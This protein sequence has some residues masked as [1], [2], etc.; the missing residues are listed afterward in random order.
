MECTRRVDWKNSSE[1]GASDG[2]NN[3]CAEMYRKKRG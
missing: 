2:T 1:S 3:I